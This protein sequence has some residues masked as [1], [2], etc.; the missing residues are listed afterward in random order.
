MSAAKPPSR[1]PRA[2]PA[3]QVALDVTR[4][5]RLRDAHAHSLIETQVRTAALPQE[6]R[7]FATLLILGVV[8]TLGELDYLLDRALTK[9]S[10]EPRVRD[11]LRIAVYEL[12]F[13]HKEPHIA[14]NQ[15]VELV[16][17]LAPRA[18]GFANK[19]LRE[20][21]KLKDE[22]PFGDPTASAQALAHEQAFPLWLAE[23][24]IADLGFHSA[25]AFMAA[26]N[27]PAPV[28]L[29]E[30]ETGV[31]RTIVPA[32]LAAHLPRIE[33]GEL[34]VADASAQAVATLVVAALAATTLATTPAPTVRQGSSTSSV[35][36]TAAWAPSIPDNLKAPSIPPV[37]QTAPVPPAALRP[38]VAFLEVGSGRG[39]KTVL[40]QRA[41]ARLYGVQP[42]LYA[43]DLHEFKRAILRERID[44][45]RLKNVTPLTGDAIH[46][47]EVLTAYAA[48]QV[49]GAAL[50]DA[51]CSG[52][53]T[54]R[55]HPEIRWRLT[56]AH[57][58]A[59]AAQGL[60][61]LTAVAPHIEP[62][63]SLI[64]STCS[65]LCE[66]NEQV[67]EAFLA[68]PRG[69]DFTLSASKPAVDAQEVNHAEC[70]RHPPNPLRTILTPGSPDAH[71]AARLVRL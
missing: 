26:S 16:R 21:A 30:L 71:F 13:L 55:R 23:R 48:P 2:T 60:A 29:A 10:I 36:Q 45:Y 49:F 31:M 5:V 43:L 6:E 57:V 3:R 11:A 27:L 61:L 41:A 54:L 62:G 65:V 17:G 37:R 70:V 69:S 44:R 39:T 7:D 46:L 38:A 34:I 32:E 9:G 51:P 18:T 58:T 40:I 64:Y 56:P 47:T 42:Q 68:S 25:A 15:G 50:I 1:T 63:G 53:G 66:E 28:F 52:T 8:A 33:A 14:V 22:F 4:Q 20:T 35:R 12:F 59:M 19:V 67:I 24:L